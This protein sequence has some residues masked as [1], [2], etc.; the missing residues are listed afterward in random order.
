M[1][2]LEIGFNQYMNSKHLSLCLPCRPAWYG[3]EGITQR[4]N[5]YSSWLDNVERCHQV[6]QVGQTDETNLARGNQKIHNN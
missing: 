6:G 1:E 3:M 5:H 2:Y 4:S